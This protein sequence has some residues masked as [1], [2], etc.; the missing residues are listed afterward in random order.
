MKNSCHYYYY[1][2]PRIMSYPYIGNPPPSSQNYGGGA[3]NQY[4]TLGGGGGGGYPSIPPAT[5]AATQQCPRNPHPGRKIEDEL[6]TCPHG[7]CYYTMLLNYTE[8]PPLA[9]PPRKVKK[10]A[11]AECLT[12]SESRY[13]GRDCV[14]VRAPPWVGPG[15]FYHLPSPREEDRANR[16][17][18][19]EQRVHEGVECLSL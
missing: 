2:F 13:Y 5:A 3:P 8:P 4:P 1:Y 19:K 12:Q 16:F 17:L 15:S 10:T 9:Q 11:R 6:F 7:L 14:C 18:P